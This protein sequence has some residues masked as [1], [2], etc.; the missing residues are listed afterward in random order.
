MQ[1]LILTV[2]PGFGGQSIKA[3]V[4]SKCTELRQ[5]FPNLYI[6]VGRFKLL[7]SIHVCSHLAV[8]FRC[9]VN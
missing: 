2:E 4:L 7:L 6:T 9:L 5:E 8:D 1:V 3:E